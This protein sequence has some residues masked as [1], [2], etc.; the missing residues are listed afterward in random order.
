MATEDG[1]E[2]SFRLAEREM[3]EIGEQMTGAWLHRTDPEALHANA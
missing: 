3:M 1:K 2:G